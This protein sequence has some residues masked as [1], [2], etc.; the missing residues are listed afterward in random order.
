MIR[1]TISHLGGGGLYGV[2]SITLF[3]AAFVGVLIWAVRLKRP[4]LNRMARL[5]LE[6]GEDESPEPD[7]S[8]E[9]HSRHE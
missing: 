7:R 9:A 2:I 4:W 5:P 8:P 1:D 3:F 6:A